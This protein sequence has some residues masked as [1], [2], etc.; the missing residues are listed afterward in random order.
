V[1]GASNEDRPRSIYALVDDHDKTLYR[2]NGLPGLTTRMKSSE[3]RLDTIEDYNEK[4]EQRH[5]N[6]MNLLLAT[7][8]TVLGGVVLAIILIA[9]HLK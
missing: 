8:F 5:E 2:G 6:K 9:F 7:V 4:K 1:S 3:D